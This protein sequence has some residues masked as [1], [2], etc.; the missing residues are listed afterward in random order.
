MRTT[1]GASG[2]CGL[3]LARGCARGAEADHSLVVRGDSARR[4]EHAQDDHATWP[5]WSLPPSRVPGVLEQA[6]PT[7]GVRV[8][9][10]D[11]PDLAARVGS[12]ELRLSLETER[13]P[14]IFERVAD[15]VIAG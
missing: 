2:M 7:L 6:A 10:F 11:L 5:R 13:P 1:C 12:L 8:V 9:G 15:D 14:L 4:V 3:S